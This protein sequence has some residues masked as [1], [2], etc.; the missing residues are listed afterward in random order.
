MDIQEVNK[1]L[2]PYKI[3][4]ECSSC[5]TSACK[6]FQNRSI[7]QK[8]NSITKKIKKAHKVKPNY[9]EFN[10]FKT[11]KVKRKCRTEKKPQSSE[12]WI[13]NIRSPITPACK[14]VNQVSKQF[15][16]FMELKLSCDKFLNCPQFENNQNNENFKNPDFGYEA[17]ATTMNIGTNKLR[18]P[19]GD[20]ED[21]RK[22]LF[23]EDN[24]N[25]DEEIKIC[26]PNTFDHDKGLIKDIGDQFEL[27]FGRI[28]AGF[29]YFALM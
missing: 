15:N 22:N 9:M 24:F 17:T 26:N 14:T 19:F 8:V 29:D 25:S 5:E 3:S 10:N 4:I 7:N 2:R 28:S 12:N 13:F 1:L 11:E 21:L 16:F 23:D 20:V 18:L 6:P 27:D